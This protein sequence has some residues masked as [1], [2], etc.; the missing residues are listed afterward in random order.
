MDPARMPMLAQQLIDE[1]GNRIIK[2]SDNN[3]STIRFKEL[4][5]TLSD[6]KIYFADMEALKKF[7]GASPQ[8][9][10]VYQPMI[11]VLQSYGVTFSPDILNIV[12]GAS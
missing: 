6:A 3:V 1:Y 2:D 8:A 7:T 4:L 12:N 5:E 9:K 10:N 11:I